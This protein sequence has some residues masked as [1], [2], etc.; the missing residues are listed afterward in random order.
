M[1]QT[2]GSGNNNIHDN[3]N[4]VNKRKLSPRDLFHGGL[5]TGKD[6]LVI[7]IGFLDG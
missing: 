5:N 7:R 4:N 6:K 1:S 3:Q 2:L